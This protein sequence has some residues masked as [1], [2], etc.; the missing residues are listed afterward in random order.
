MSI[1]NINNRPA[2]DRDNLA[3][4]GASAAEGSSVVFQIKKRR[5]EVKKKA[6]SDVARGL[7]EVA[8]S[9]GL[10]NNPELFSE[11]MAEDIFEALKK[12]A[13]KKPNS[14]QS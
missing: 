13:K 7:A 10:T 4:R 1:N 3:Q 8:E 12:V 5:V 2:S 6:V 14:P 11:Q 9:M